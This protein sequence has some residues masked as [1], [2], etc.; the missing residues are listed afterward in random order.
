MKFTSKLMIALALTL[1]LS[2]VSLTVWAAPSPQGTIPLI[3]VTGGTISINY[4]CGCKADAVVTRFSE[5]EMEVGPAPAGFD[6]LSDTFKLENV[7]DIEICY[8]YPEDYKD[9]KGQI[10]MWDAGKEE[11]GLTDST[12]Y[13]EPKQICTVV[14]K[15]T[16][17]IYS[18]ITSDQ[19]KSLVSPSKVTL[20]GCSAGDTV[21]NIK[22]PKTTVGAAPAG[23]TILTDATKV[24]CSAACEVKVCY[25]YTE[26]NKSKDGQ[27]YKWD[28]TNNAWGVVVSTIDEDN[29][30]IC[31]LIN[32]SLG[33]VFTLIGR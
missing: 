31:T 20:C 9:Q 8:P 6:F 30:Q 26:E 33:G 24:E 22:D 12:I 7:C 18:L 16:G 13:G 27:I 25:P 1:I 2:L 29:E 23:L 10:Y 5:P 28:E 32:S 19:I 14:K 4:L 17:N 21:T 15:S 3:P 11:W